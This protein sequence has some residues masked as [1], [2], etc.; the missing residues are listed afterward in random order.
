MSYTYLQE[1]GGESSAECFSDIPQSVLSRLNL[2]A[3]KSSSKGSETESFQGFQSGMMSQPLTEHLGGAKLMSFAEGSLAK[4]SAQQ[5]QITIS[6]GS[7][8][9][10]KEVAADFGVRCAELLTKFNL[11][12]LLLKTPRNCGHADL[13]LCCETLPRWGIM[14]DGECL[15]FAAL[16]RIISESGF[17]STLPT[18]TCHNAKEGNY[19]AEHTRKTKTLA[20]QIGGKVNPNWNEWRMGWPIGWTDLKPLET[21]KFQQW[22]HSHGVHFNSNSI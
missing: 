9:G 12:L 21:D 14:L 22:R 2:T 18:P 5:E 17:L 1:Q 11:K 10:C 19:P 7:R 20:A 13:A 4:I 16:A 6:M 3:E 15:E 8:G